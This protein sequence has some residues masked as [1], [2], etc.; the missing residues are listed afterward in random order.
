MI[1]DGGWGGPTIVTHAGGQQGGYGVGYGGS[2]GLGGGY[3][4]GGNG[5]LGGWGGGGGGMFPHFA[6]DA[7]GGAYGVGSPV[8]TTTTTTVIPGGGTGGGVPIVGRGCDLVME[9]PMTGPMVPM[10]GYGRRSNGWFGGGGRSSNRRV[11]HERH[12]YSESAPVA[13]CV[14]M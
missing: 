12:S 11:R 14:V 1:A 4:Y 7:R 2:G 9:S 13:G 10:G 8:T 6:G 3:G 5:F